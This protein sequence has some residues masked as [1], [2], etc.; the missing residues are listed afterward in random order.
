MTGASACRRVARAKCYAVHSGQFVASEA[1]PVS[2]PCQDEGISWRTTR[3]YWK[4]RAIVCRG[5]SWS[6]ELD[7]KELHGAPGA[8]E[9][10][11]Q[12]VSVFWTTSSYRL[13]VPLYSSAT[14]CG[15]FISK[16]RVSFCNAE[17]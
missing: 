16:E 11:S 14:E 4:L 3:R 12:N 5:A 17:N 2:T 13:L 10:R 1:R 9:D 6:E 7:D 15:R 8:R